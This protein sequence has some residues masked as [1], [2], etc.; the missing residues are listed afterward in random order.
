MR[1]KSRGTID[2]T[3]KTGSYARYRTSDNRVVGGP[4]PTSSPAHRGFVHTIKYD[5][6]KRSKKS[7]KTT[8][9]CDH[10]TVTTEGKYITEHYAEPSGAYYFKG[11]WYLSP[12]VA[13]LEPIGLPNVSPYHSEALQF[14]KSGCTN[15]EVDLALDLWELGQVKSLLPNLKTTLTKFGKSLRKKSVK[16][17]LKGSADLHLTYA[18]GIA[19]LVSSVNS[20]IGSFQDLQKK[21][22]HLR[23]NSGK[24]VRVDFR[25]DLSSS[26][27]PP[28]IVSV[29]NAN[30][31]VQTVVREYRAVYHA[32]AVIT[33][34]V[35][36]LSDMELRLRVLAKQFGLDKPL[37]TLWNHL[38]WSFVIDWIF[39]VSRVLDS[40]QPTITL[41]YRFHDLG[42]S[43]K[44]ERVDELI[45]QRHYPLS[46]SGTNS[47]KVRRTRYVRHPGIPASYSS[48]SV[49]DLNLRQLAL[50]ASL[51]L[52][53]W[54]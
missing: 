11:T 17:T 50:S 35:S 46:G 1:T 31:K 25:K 38:P 41:P 3:A 53:K 15:Q 26:L 21:I 23:K 20:L 13:L 36:K 12:G 51:A 47:V 28:N 33:Y 14:F 24:Q 49:D 39:S 5:D 29:N 43:V 30:E 40:F 16:G 37:T 44:V 10:T 54:R 34:D 48:L 32:F 18:F 22:A 9:Y 45:L 6:S 42:Y 2:F 52:Q 8:R 19:P 27:K 4:W 7:P